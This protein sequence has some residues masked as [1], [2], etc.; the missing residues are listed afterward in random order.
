[1]ASR[2]DGNAAKRAPWGDPKRFPPPWSSWRVKQRHLRAIRWIQT[3]F[4]PPKGYGAG[5]PLKLAKFQKEW[6]EDVYSPGVMSA[7]MELPRGN[8]KSTFLAAVAAH[9]L[10]DEDESGAP[11][12]PIVATTINQAIRTTYGVAL[13]AISECEELEKRALIY[14]AIGGTKVRTPHNGGE[15]FPQSNDPDGLQ[16]L[17]PSIAICDEVGFMPIESWSSLLL[18]SGKRPHSLVIGIGTPGFDRHSALWHLRTREL[19]G[20]RLPGFLFTEYAAPENCSIYDEEMW[21]EANPALAEGYMNIDALRT[22]VAL[23]PEAHF[24]IF[25]LG[26][27]VDGVESWLGTDGRAL[28]RALEDPYEMVPSAKTWVGVDIGL[29]HDSTAVVWIQQRPN[30]KYHV[31][32]KVWLPVPDGR[33]DVSDAMR[34]I[35]ELDAMYDVAGI[36]YDPR[37]FDLPAQQLVDEGL[38]MLEV[39]Q[40]LERMTPAAGLAYEMVKRHEISHDGDPVLET[41]VLNAVA[42]YNERGFTLAKSRSKDRIDAAVAMVLAL[43]EAARPEESWA[44][45]ISFF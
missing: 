12:V 41:Q 17:D 34:F 38:A 18:A 21:F 43:F 19:S 37:Y 5:K 45:A 35:R 16:G 32:A 29:K 23:S 26:Q 44:P 6:L 31:K 8:G 15:M 13:A 27:W 22:A 24:R 40:S 11:Q 25:R 42:R 28:W 33:L 10:F 14:S 30:G 1:M 7:A 39:P 9:A 20:D 36:A 4:V 3:F 2:A